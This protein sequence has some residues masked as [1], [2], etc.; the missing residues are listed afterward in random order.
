MMHGK[1]LVTMALIDAGII[2]VTVPSQ[3]LHQA[4]ALH[5]WQFFTAL[6]VHGDVE[7]ACSQP[8]RV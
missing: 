2:I 4:C 8:V 7:H 3:L 1:V 5:D 6:D